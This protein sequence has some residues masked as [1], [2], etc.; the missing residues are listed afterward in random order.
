MRIGEITRMLHAIKILDGFKTYKA[1][2]VYRPSNGYHR[3]MVFVLM[4]NNH[5]GMFC[6]SSAGIE[7]VNGG[8]NAYVTDALDAL[9]EFRRITDK[10]HQRYRDYL[11]KQDQARRKQQ[12]IEELERLARRYGYTVTEPKSTAQKIRVMQQLMKKRAGRD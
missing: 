4:A 12:D 6:E 7:G 5:I 9:E 2:A 1:K 10:D 3:D 8:F 11:H